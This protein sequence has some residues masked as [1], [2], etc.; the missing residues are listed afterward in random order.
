MR[1][2]LLMR[3]IYLLAYFLF[4]VLILGCEKSKVEVPSYIQINE[5]LLN[6]N[7]ATQGSN[8]AKFTDAWV[9]VNDKSVGTFELPAK[10]PVQA[11]GN[12][13]I[14]IGA[15]INLNGA[16]ASRQSPLIFTTCVIDT[17]LKAAGVIKLSPTVAYASYAKFAWLENFESNGFTLSAYSSSNNITTTTNTSKVFEGNRCGIFSLTDSSDA[18]SVMS[19]SAYVLPKDG[20][21]IY[22]ELNYSC[23]VTF[24]VG[25]IVNSKIQS[26]LAKQIIYLNATTNDASAPKWN[27]IYISLTKG[28]A[29]E[30]TAS[31]INILF[32]CNKRDGVSY[33]EVLI[34]NI[35]VVY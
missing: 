17:L 24:V 34:D 11:N 7:I 1:A 9:T 30:Q 5:I 13:K 2:R 31:D 21:N 14:G 8:S 4:A 12:V 16:T 35:K 23:S 32:S 18:F 33:D 15:G 22:L 28:V 10:F 25:L 27:K 3:R 20:T 29:E 26:S 6:T 19:T